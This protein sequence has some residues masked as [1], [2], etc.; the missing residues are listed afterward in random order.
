MPPHCII[1]GDEVDDMGTH[2]GENHEQE[3]FLE[4]MEAYR[5]EREPQ[6]QITR[7]HSFLKYYATNFLT[8][9]SQFD[10]RIQ[11]TNEKFYH[12]GPNPIEELISEAMVISTPVA[13]K[14][15]HKKLGE[16][17]NQFEDQFGEIVEDDGQRRQMHFEES[18][19]N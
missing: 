18:A 2:M 10:F 6:F 15:L 12:D 7:S 1:C 11:V 9:F 14:V 5:G 13:A 19:S 8:D 16:T 4:A 17:I 3:E